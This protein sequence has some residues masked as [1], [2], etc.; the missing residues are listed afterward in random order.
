M[1]PGL[2]APGFG[3]PRAPPPPST[4][5]GAVGRGDADVDFVVLAVE[6]PE[7][8]AFPDG[9]EGPPIVT[10]TPCVTVV[11]T[12]RGGKVVVNVVNEVDIW[13][14]DGDGDCLDVEQREQIMVGL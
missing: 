12:V 13:T 9:R 11:P 2:L 3:A 1:P 14:D 4:S 5:V 8:V 7:T 6:F 10:M